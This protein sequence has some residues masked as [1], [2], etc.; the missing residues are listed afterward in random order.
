[1]KNNYLGLKAGNLM[2][3]VVVDVVFGGVGGGYGGGGS[4]G[5]GG[6]GDGNGNSGAPTTLHYFFLLFRSKSQGYPGTDV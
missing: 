6:D 3:V 4:G 2:A 5:S 1:M